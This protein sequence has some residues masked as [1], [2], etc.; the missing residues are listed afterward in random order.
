M[1]QSRLMWLGL[2]AGVAAGG[3]TLIMPATTIDVTMAGKKVY[4][5]MPFDRQGIGHQLHS[6]KT[7]SAIVSK[8]ARKNV[9]RNDIG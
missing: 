6:C 9:G 5:F 2:L 4:N 3:L 8:S 7:N 1:A